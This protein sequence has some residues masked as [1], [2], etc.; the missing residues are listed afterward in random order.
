MYAKEHHFIYFIIHS[1]GEDKAGVE[2]VENLSHLTIDE[3]NFKRQR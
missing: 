3:K 2:K 1:E